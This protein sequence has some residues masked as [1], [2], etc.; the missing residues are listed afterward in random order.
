MFSVTFHHNNCSGYFD[1]TRHRC[2]MGNR[3]SVCPSSGTQF[4][5]RCGEKLRGNKAT[6]TT[7]SLAPP[8]LSSSIS[9][10]TQGPGEGDTHTHTH[11]PVSLWVSCLTLV[12]FLCRG[13]DHRVQLYKVTKYFYSS[14]FLYISYSSLHVSDYFSYF[15]DS[16]Y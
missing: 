14:T 15:A 8:T 10:E 7:P 11:T 3:V 6:G 4:L 1:G 5:L 9:M 12:L 2:I 13:G 16:E